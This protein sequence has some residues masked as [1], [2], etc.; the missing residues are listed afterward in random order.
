MRLSPSKYDALN[1]CPCFAYADNDGTPNPAAEEGT[2]LHSALETGN[3]EGLTEE[4]AGVIAR[5]QEA[6]EAL[7][8]GWLGWNPDDRVNFRCHNE[9]R[10]KNT[11]N[12]SGAMDQCYVSLVKQRALI[13]DLKTGRLGLIAEAADSYQMAGYADAVFRMYESLEEVMVALI[14]PRTNELSTHTYKAEDRPRIHNMLAELERRVDNPFKKPQVHD[15]LCGKCKYLSSCPAAS[16]VVE[17]GISFAL[18][19]PTSTLLAPVEELSAEEISK[20]LAMIDL[21]A[22]Y[23]EARKPLLTQRV[24]TEGLEVP[25]Y[26]KREREG[27]AYVSAEDTVAAFD[28]LRGAMTVE[29]FVACCGKPSLSKLTEKLMIDDGGSK[30][31][32]KREARQGLEDAL[33]DLLRH[34]NPVQFLQRSAKLNSELL[35]KS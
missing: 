1:Q 17:P 13:G 8:V 23:A 27:N 3:T 22:K 30:A 4:Q 16:A 28:K 24:F 9:E 31:A 35:L 12:H 21:I 32:A 34:G 33:G 11:L 7:K 18:S 20:N 2:Q 10:V 6:M 25:G 26:S 29:D 15:I 5:T 19:F 14:S